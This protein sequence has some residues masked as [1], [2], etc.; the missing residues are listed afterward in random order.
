MYIKLS[1]SQAFTEPAA[2]VSKVMTV[3]QYR[4]SIVII[5]IIIILMA[6]DQWLVK[7]KNKSGRIVFFC[8]KSYFKM[9]TY[10]RS[11]LLWCILSFSY[12]DRWCA[13]FNQPLPCL[14]HTFLFG[15]ACSVKF[16]NTPVPLENI[17]GEVG[18]GFKVI[19]S[20]LNPVYHFA[21]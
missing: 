12:T 5:I 11:V 16:D 20:I 18:D 3:W 2:N 17:I 19:S 10:S 1:F 14:M 8:T 7:H 6:A 13:S 21:G 15:I 4:N 9:L